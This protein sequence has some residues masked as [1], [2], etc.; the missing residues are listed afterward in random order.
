MNL[1]LSNVIPDPLLP[2]RVAESQIWDEQ[3]E[4]N[5]GERIHV[6]A[7]SGS[8]KTTFI[9]ILYGLRQ[10][11]KGAVEIDGKDLS[12]LNISEKAHV[13]QKSLSVV[14]QDLRLFPK[15]T[16]RENI[17]LNAELQPGKSE[18]EWE[19]MAAE[20]G[21]G[22]KL[23]RPVSTL[24]QGE[25]QRIAIIRALSQPFEWLFLDEPFSHL[26]EDN[27][28]K[29]MQLVQARADELNAGILLAG[30]GYEKSMSLD[31]EIEL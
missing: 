27:S 11:F 3:V 30:L 1:K 6:H 14:F 8:G 7:P 24:S 21:M 25:R 12:S 4:F 18:S 26:D 9:H 28:Q 29:A 16:G 10:D 15:L 19:S 13:R 23:D 5:A 22:N 2:A 17:R 20:L 31:R